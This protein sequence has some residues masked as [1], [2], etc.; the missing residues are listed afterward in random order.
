MTQRDKRTVA[1]LVVEHGEIFLDKFKGSKKV[2]GIY[3]CD[4]ELMD[5]FEAGLNG[6]FSGRGEFVEIKQNSS[7]GYP[8]G[9]PIDLGYFFNV[10]QVKDSNRDID[11][12]YD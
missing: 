4:C 11:V 8:N 3:G 12:F 5:L 2:I 1:S 6:Y 10:G 9:Y 7:V